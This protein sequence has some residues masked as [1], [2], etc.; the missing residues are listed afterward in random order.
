MF[1][2]HTRWMPRC[3]TPKISSKLSQHSTTHPIPSLWEYCTYTLVWC[4]NVFLRF[5]VSFACILPQPGPSLDIPVCI[6]QGIST[7]RGYEMGL[8]IYVHQD[9]ASQTHGIVCRKIHRR[10][11]CRYSFLGAGL[12]YMY[13]ICGYSCVS[14]SWCR[15]THFW[16]QAFCSII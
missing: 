4:K 11:T 13:A 2:S 10:E 6:K 16:M 9:K 1:T 7:L 15:S 3:C 5:C 8:Y 14:P 12:L